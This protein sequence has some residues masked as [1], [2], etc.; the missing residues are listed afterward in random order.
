LAVDFGLIEVGVE[1][2]RIGPIA[3][4][5]DEFVWEDQSMAYFG[6]GRDKKSHDYYVREGAKS[7]PVRLAGAFRGVKGKSGLRKATDRRPGILPNSSRRLTAAGTMPAIKSLRVGTQKPFHP[8]R[9][10][11]LWRFQ[12]KMKV[13]A[14]QAVGVPLPASLRARLSKGKQKLLPVLLIKKNG[15]APVPTALDSPQRRQA[16]RF[17]PISPLPA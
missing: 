2:T 5:H 15:F 6:T 16:I 10:I 17:A 1:V 7:H 8:C 13:I 9:Q 12:D 11:G 3:H 4:I 14:H